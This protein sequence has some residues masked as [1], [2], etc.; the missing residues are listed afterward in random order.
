MSQ[1]LRPGAKPTASPQGRAYLSFFAAFSL[2]EMWTMMGKMP[3][4][5]K[6][7]TLSSRTSS[8]AWAFWGGARRGV[9]TTLGSGRGA[10]VGQPLPERRRWS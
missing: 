4:L 7:R 8:R 9:K 1:E 10:W 2:M 5:C 6:A 3:T